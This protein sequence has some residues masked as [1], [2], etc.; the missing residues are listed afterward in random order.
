M[1]NPALLAT[2]TYGILALLG[3]IMGY[4]RARSRVSLASGTVRGVLLLFAGFL[5]L[6]GYNWGLILATVITAV[7]IVVFA[8][9]LVK[10]RKAMPAGLMIVA[11][12]PVL[13][14]LIAQF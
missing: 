12:I 3:G 13:I 1:M 14:L 6:Q 8:V 9:R 10:T 4:V 7:L 5:Q 2:L 11:G